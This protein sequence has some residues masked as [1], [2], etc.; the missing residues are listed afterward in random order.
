MIA[1]MMTDWSYVTFDSPDSKAYVSIVFYPWRTNIFNWIHQTAERDR[2]YY[3]ALYQ[4]VDRLS[5]TNPDGTG[6]AL[7]IYRVH[8]SRESCVMQFGRNFVVEHT[9]SFRITT[10]ICEQSLDDY[11]DIVDDSVLSF[12][13]H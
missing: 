2:K 8:V 6:W 4:L 13:L 7:F 5:S 12:D 1:G 9:Q 11:E 3:K 10:G